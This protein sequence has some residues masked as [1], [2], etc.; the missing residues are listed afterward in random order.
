MRRCL[1]L[2]TLLLWSAAARAET[3]VASFSVLGDMARQIGGPDVTVETLVGPDGDVHVFQP[4]PADARKMAGATLFIANGLALEGW[5]DRLER[6]SGFAGRV[7]TASDGITKLTNGEGPDPHAWQDVA[8]AR[9]YARNIAAALAATD[10]AH[11]DGYRT[12]AAEYDAELADLD[13]WIRQAIAAVPVP[14]RRI[15]TTHDAFGYFGR[16]YGIDFKAPV[17]MTEDSEPS[18]ASVAALIREIRH[19]GTKALFIENMTDPRLIA[20]LAAE[21]GTTVGGTLFADALSRPDEG[22]ETYIAMMRHNVTLMVAA[23]EENRDG[24]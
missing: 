20:Q 10:P 15:I 19:D 3:V 13:N 23:M 14:K 24:G 5:L 6:S 2:A 17:G 22:G 4:S 18:A 7:A 16:A 12:R 21:T 9:I 11:A 8:A 1:V